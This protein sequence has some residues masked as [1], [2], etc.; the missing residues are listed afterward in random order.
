MPQCRGMP[1]E[2]SRS[3]WLV[4][5]GGGEVGWGIFTGEMRK[6]NKI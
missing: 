5:G 1:R 6:R 2:G 3:G 4:R